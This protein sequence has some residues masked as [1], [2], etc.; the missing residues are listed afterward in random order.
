VRSS[1]R[2]PVMRSREA[3]CNGGDKLMT[4]LAPK[5]HG[6]ESFRGFM[7]NVVRIVSAPP[8]VVVRA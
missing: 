4:V 2:S 3:I 1:L 6:L 7:R 8:C 5:P